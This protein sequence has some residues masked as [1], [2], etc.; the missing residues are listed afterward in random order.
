MVKKEKLWPQK[1]EDCSKKMDKY[2]KIEMSIGLEIEINEDKG[3]ATVSITT[4]LKT[5]Y[6]ENTAFQKSLLYFALRSLWQKFYYGELRA[7]YKEYAI[8]LTDEVNDRL[9]EFLTSVK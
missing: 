2:T 7:K 8:K 5:E 3:K 6:P 4:N 9:I 1:Q